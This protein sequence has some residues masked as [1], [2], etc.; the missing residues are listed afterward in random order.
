MLP[1]KQCLYTS[2]S[3]WR[4]KLKHGIK[5]LM[6]IFNRKPELRYRDVLGPSETATYVGYVLEQ[7][8]R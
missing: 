2:E 1:I 6:R 5:P 4:C 8:E 7:N 3:R